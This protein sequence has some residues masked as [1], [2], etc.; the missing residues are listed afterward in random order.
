MADEAYLVRKSLDRRSEAIQPICM[1]A[2]FNNFILPY[3]TLVTRQP[4]SVALR[5]RSWIATPLVA[6]RDDGLDV[7][8]PKGNV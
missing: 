7:Y 5:I 2:I 6:A 4:I 1:G 3:I 8:D